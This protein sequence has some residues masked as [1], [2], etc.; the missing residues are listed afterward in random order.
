MAN[1]D[2]SE[3]RIKFKNSFMR[4]RV[5]L[6]LG[7]ALLLLLIGG[8]YAI[9][10][11]M[12]TSDANVIK[13][14]QVSMSYAESNTIVSVANGLPMT[15]AEGKKSSTYFDFTITSNAS[16]NGNDNYGVA[17]PYNLILQ[18][19][20]LATG[21][22]KL[23]SNQIKVYLTKVENGV[24]T[25]VIAPTLI[26]HLPILDQNYRLYATENVHKN[27]NGAITTNY[28]LRAWIDYKVE[29]KELTKNHQYKFS[30]NVNGGDNVLEVKQNYMKVNPMETFGG[31]HSYVKRLVIQ[32]KLSP[33]DNAIANADMSQAGDGSVMAYVTVDDLATMGIIM[34][35][36]QN[37][38][39]PTFD[40]LNKV[41]ATMYIQADGKIMAPENSMGLFKDFYYLN[42]MEG[43]ENLDTSHVTDMSMMFS[44]IGT[45]YSVLKDQDENINVENYL[46]D[47]D[48]RSFDTSKVTNMSGM[49]SAG[50]VLLSSTIRNLDL[51]SFDTSKVTD[52]S[53]MFWGT[54]FLK[55]LDF[56]QATFD[57]VIDYGS[58]ER[59]DY[60]FD[61][62]NIKIITKN[63]T[64]KTWL[65]ARLDEVN[66]TGAT[67][68][69]VE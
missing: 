5:S 33:I 48:L 20:E 26:S 69:T 3:G 50:G 25:Q 45:L 59:D 38:Q 8:S 35:K 34:D 43:L 7:F 49:F 62:P 31:M 36:L 46:I 64:T 51:S 17:I 47:L 15:D 40:E 1:K 68:T 12:K 4:K 9:V 66:I 61:A 19:K 58:F 32:N 57:N 13:T 52:M 27:N 22:T 41:N 30:V 42:K 28:R 14:G 29:A 6:L 60:M 11:F 16:T 55:F 39:F 2:S 10:N 24:E 44:G 37:S 54:R 56:R 23:A 65:Q 53:A 18:E 67:I 21:K 63:A